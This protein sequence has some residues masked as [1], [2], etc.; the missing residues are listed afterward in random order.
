MS[1]NINELTPYLAYATPP[2]VGAFIGY[3]T[4]RV[5]IRMLFRPLKQW[6]IGPVRVPMTPG[7]IPSKRHELAVNIGEMVGEHLLTSDEINR[8]L[9]KSGFQDHL[10]R[11]IEA[12]VGSFMKKD[13][14]PLQSLVPRDYRSYF[15]IAKKTVTYQIKET[16][17]DYLSTEQCSVA[18][19][20]STSEWMD[21]LFSRELNEIV[22]PMLREKLYESVDTQIHRILQEESTE[23]WVEDY[24][25][26]KIIDSAN[27]ET[28]L[29]EIL[30]KSMIE[31]ILHVID[32][33]TPEL[34][35]QGV[36]ILEEPEIQQKIVDTIMKGIEEFIETL[37]PMAAMVKN[38]LDM[39]M[40]EEKIKE[41]F[42]EKQDDI[43][44]L[45]TG[46]DVRLRVSQALT[47]RASLL[48]DSS[49][50]SITA[51]Q[52]ILQL[53]TFSR[54]LTAILFSAVRSPR[55]S[56]IINDLF[57][58]HLENQINSGSSTVGDIVTELF[59]ERGREG[60]KI[61]VTG[62]I[63]NVLKSTKTKKVIDHIL[64]SM[65]EQLLKKPV[66][67]LANLVPAG[68]RDGLYKSMQEMATKMLTS[69][70]PGIV[71]SLNIRQIV[72]DRIDSFD[73]LRLEML[74][75][76]IMEEQFKY[77][78]I[79]GGLLGFLIGCLNVV[80]MRGIVN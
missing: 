11:L 73:L 4:N 52:N 20:Q 27:N 46:E 1:V 68:V 77:I 74:L 15:D 42:N 34:L 22:S 65:I 58:N 54:E 78:N 43:A 12:K 80:F 14:G 24:I 13:L 41:Y 18:I 63:R 70:V 8:S 45:I 71:K 25:Y 36:K 33:Q 17:S 59:G 30:P 64:E 28:R 5:A 9:K 29:C 44:E 72:T 16:V 10:Y 76:S 69:E 55:T 38:F 56:G 21:E 2:V 75:L 62:E 23:T 47:Q 57:K 35:A 3:L 6:R 7:V 67:R 49:I 60:S 39:A 48:F 31:S 66:G 19:E 37:G 53:R 26:R 79:F 61:W 51:Q 50:K 40:V 32:D